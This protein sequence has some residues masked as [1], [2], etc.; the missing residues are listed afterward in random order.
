MIKPGVIIGARY[1]IIDRIGSGGM[2]DVYKAVDRVLKRYVAMKV[3][4]REFREDE[5]FV[6]K[7]RSEAQA[8]AGLTHPNIVNVYDVAEDRG[9]HY[10]VMELVE[11][12]T[13]K[14]YIEK[15]G[16]LTPKEVI[17]I[18]MQVCAGIDAAHSNR[19][20]HRDIKPQNIMISKEGKVKVT[21]FGI[22]KATSSN[23]ISTNAMG[24][25]HYTSPEQARGGYSDEKSDIYSLGIT[26]YEMVT[27][28]LPFDGDTTVSIALKHLQEDIVP[29]SDFVPDIPY[30]LEQIILKCTQKSPDRRYG[31]V[32]LLSRDLKRS[33]QD[34]DG[35]FV[36][37]S[38]LVTVSD[39]VMI[40]P[41]DL[42][43]IQGSTKFSSGYDSEDYD[44]YYD[45]DERRK[46]RRKAN[47]KGTEMDPKMTKLIKTLTISAA[48]I[49]VVAML[50]VVANV[51]GIFKGNVGPGISATDEKYKVPNLVG[52]TLDEAK[53]AC[54]KVGLTL[55]VEVEEKALKYDK[56][57]IFKQ[58]PQNGTKML[59]GAKVQVHV[60]TGYKD[61]TVPE[62]AGKGQDAAINALEEDGFD[63]KKMEVKHEES[64]TVKKGLVIKTDPAAGTTGNHASEIVIYISS[65]VG[66]TKMP[67][68][69]GKTKT[70]AE[71][72][73]K[74]AGLVSKVVEV[75]KV[76]LTEENIDMVIEQS[77]E[78]DKELDKG[79]T[80]EY[81]I[82]VKPMVTVPENI[83][84][85]KFDEAVD[86]LNSLNF[87]V[88]LR[89][90]ASSKE[91]NKV[92]S[93]RY[94]GNDV[95]GK[96]VEKGV[97]LVVTYSK[98]LN[99]SSEDTTTGSDNEN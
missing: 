84:G 13:L 42:E 16:K 34:P 53:A 93:V 44:E 7:F 22:A 47:E 41:E 61:I 95:A 92:I 98:G 4:K 20:I 73:I 88:E 37:I 90:T 60:S 26:M 40:T 52:M 76:G 96:K 27:G 66:K 81:M 50:V 55:S 10:I 51:V 25:V 17:G 58:I 38:P 29:P 57:Y 75:E 86:K 54:S 23:T 2:A 45:E 33:V 12:I 62:V 91:K 36:R 89:E 56:N 99:A 35:D 97:T 70:E 49:F 65:G 79:T 63:R 46:Q 6:K 9:L 83:I 19:I 8:A 71:K 69:V 15:K 72:L 87:T 67:D 39:T 28:Q 78:K 48:V 64:M 43:H 94:D 74:D 14:E 5:N 3:L 31:D 59:E 32:S 68:L 77:V 18:T 82:A 85:M 24:S 11:G 80:V 1:E 21:D 30:S